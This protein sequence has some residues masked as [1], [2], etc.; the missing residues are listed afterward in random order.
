MT[1]T[2]EKP[3]GDTSAG[4]DTSRGRSGGLAFRLALLIAVAIV[5]L[6]LLAVLQTQSLQEAASINSEVTLSG[7]TLSAAA[8]HVEIIHRAVATVETLALNRQLLTQ[9]S[10]ACS[11]VMSA[12][13]A[14][15]PEYALVTFVPVSGIMECS[16][17]GRNFNF[18]NN[19]IFQRIIRLPE[20]Q[21]F[22]S[23]SGDQSN[24]AFLGVTHPVL[25]DAGK[26]IG[27]VAIAIPH[28][29]IES[30]LLLQEKS[31]KLPQPVS[32]IT[33]ANEG[34]ILYSST[35]LKGVES[36]LPVGESLIGLAEQQRPSF[37]SVAVDGETRSYAFAML[38]DGLYLLGSWR[39]VA[40]G[41]FGLDLPPYAFPATMWAMGILVAVLAS[42]ALVTR[43]ILTLERSMTAFAGGNRIPVNLS[44]PG[45]PNEIVSLAKVYRNMI[46]II[47]RDE[48]ELENLL[49]H[50][51]ILLREVHHR[52][53]N[54][55]QLIASIIR[56]HLR[57]NPSQESR[58][59]LAGLHDRV[60]SLAT[61]HLG[62]YQTSDQPDVD[63]A[64]LLPKVAGQMTMLAERAGRQLQINT[65]VE[66]IRLGA[67]QAVPLCLLISEVLSDLSEMAR[68]TKDSGLTLEA[69]LSLKRRGMTGAVLRISMPV[70]QGPA[71]ALS[72]HRA[73]SVISAQLVE[74]FA[75]QLEGSLV[76]ERTSEES[77]FQISF[78]IRHT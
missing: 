34:E 76:V 61:V 72:P 62:L 41:I 37:T 51:Q 59:L 36:Y 6:G 32:F 13:K 49:R 19:K 60:M 4:Q 57:Q 68:K 70:G 23:P 66:S 38:A 78:P 15:H 25:D 9:D 10:A 75:A 43:H 56:L 24:T 77:V 46:E 3:A 44:M 42:S 11:Q 33:F 54:S 35:G 45:A 55:L 65:S 17:A 8:P 52:T 5:P 63:M 21:F 48:A 29:E 20:A 2:D 7:L 16:S 40:Q 30:A 64:E 28:S 47:L 39:A 26:I 1:A 12:I 73:T 69:G 14:L 22:V 58:A 31:S 67:D 71:A 53:G 18:A 74:G 50:K 27:I